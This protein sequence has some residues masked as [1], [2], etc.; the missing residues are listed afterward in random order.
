M[1]DDGTSVLRLMYDQVGD[2]DLHTVSNSVLPL[3]GFT[4]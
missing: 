4:V 1:F 3:L 2:C